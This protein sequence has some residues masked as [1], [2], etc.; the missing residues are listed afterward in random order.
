MLNRIL[1][2]VIIVL[3]LCPVFCYP[4]S[5]TSSI[6]ADI[7]SFNNHNPHEKV[8]LHIDRPYYNTGDT[9]WL[10]AYVLNASLGYSKQS[11]I[12]YTELINNAGWVVLRQAMPM[13]LGISFGQIAID[14][15]KFAEGN[16]TIR[17]YTNWMQNQGT[18]SFFSRQIYI[19]NASENSWLVNKSQ[20]LDG[21]TGNEDIVLSFQK[22][23][24]E[25]VRLRSIQVS[26]KD[27]SRILS[28]QLLQTDL[29]GMLSINIPEKSFDG[30]ALTIEARDNE[31]GGLPHLVEIPVNGAKAANIDLQFMPEGGQLIVGLK[32]LVGFKTTNE[33]GLGVD[34]HGSV[35]NSSGKTIVP[36]TSLHNGIGAF[37]FMPEAGESYTAKTILPDGTIKNY[38]LPVAQPFG[39]GM[40]IVNNPAKDS[41]TVVLQA[42]DGMKNDVAG[43]SL[44]AQSAEKICYAAHVHFDNGDNAVIGKV[45]KENFATGLV[46]FILFTNDKKPIAERLIFIDHNDGLKVQLLAEKPIYEAGDSIRLKIQ[47]NNKDNLPVQGSFSLAVTDN[48]QV[49]ADSTN[50]VNIENYMWLNAG[51]SGYIQEPDYYFEKKNQDRFAALDNLLLTQGWVAYDWK[52]VFSNT[53][54]PAF[55]PEPDIAVSGHISRVG[56]SS[57]SGLK[58]YLLSTKR[59]FLAMDTVT[60]T[61]GNFV[62]NNLPR[63]DTANFLLQLKDKKGKMFEANISVDEFSPA[64]VALPKIGP[65]TPW[66]VNT[67]STVMNFAHQNIIRTKTADEIKYP[68]GVRK[69]R[70]VVIKA[71]KIVKG[72]HNLNGA[73]N[74]DQVFNEA[75]MKKAGKRSLEDILYTSVKGY[76]PYWIYDKG[77]KFVIDGVDVDFFYDGNMQ[78]DRFAYLHDILQ[79]FTAEDIKGIE[80]LYSDQYNGQY[81]VSY[82]PEYMKSPRESW[83]AYIEIT[84]WSGNG[85]FEKRR[86]SAYLYSPMPVSWPKQFYIPKYSPKGSPF[87]E[88]AP[89][90]YWSPDIVTDEKGIAHITFYTKHKPSVYTIIV[91]GADLNNSIGYTS[92]NIK[93]K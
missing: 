47:V 8:F 18:G 20:K 10:K 80:V 68:L 73:G 56:N 57:I 82:D 29:D 87:T 72:S 15:S 51:L 86:R 84:T 49:R 58:I 7:D 50:V 46:R 12:L 43:Y 9:I 23:N 71:V 59:P 64:K 40:H 24:K 83:P 11:G 90:L 52:D 79:Q 66:Y 93:V 88:S 35:I 70:E 27:G 48:D 34:V 53:Y 54:K 22:I 85:L 3:V 44:V 19:G 28:K 92:R 38:P 41:V 37:E 45:S 65:V 1:N 63:I 55:K 25:P 81:V 62:F 42:S 76:R 4:Q 2:F 33:M 6:V 21:K 14:S 60:D 74:A 91:N 39:I 89:T 36:F 13:K 31:K 77:L 16:Y 30:K 75:D 17:A 26:L 67:D 32:S 69:L 61:K 5:A 78:P